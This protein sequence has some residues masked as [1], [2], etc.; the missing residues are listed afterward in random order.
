MQT[1]II[2]T[3]VILTGGAG[4][5]WHTQQQLSSIRLTHEELLGTAA[6]LGITM[7]PAHPGNLLYLTNHGRVGREVGVQLAAAEFI[8]FAKDMA[9]YTEAG[10]NQ[11]AGP[12][13]QRLMEFMD[14]MMALNSAQ[15]K[16]LIAE[17]AANNELKDEIRQDLIGFSIMTLANEQPHAALR[18]FDESSA[19]FT[20][21]RVGA[22]VLATSLA[23]WAKDDPLAALKWLHH[24]AGKKA[25][26][27]TEDT[28]LGMVSAA[29]IQYPKFA[30]KLIADLDL[31]DAPHAIQCVVDAADTPQQR[32]ATIAGLRAYLDTLNDATAKEAT[33]SSVFHDLALGSM[34]DGF[35]SASQWLASARLTPTELENF[36]AGLTPQPKSA[37][38]GRWIEWLGNALPPEQAEE[39]IRGFVSTWTQNDCQAAGQWLGSAADSAAKHTAIRAYAETVASY[40]PQ[41]A[42]QWALTMPEGDERDAT[43]K[44]IYQNWPKTD[45]AAIE[46]AAAFAKEHGIE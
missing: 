17:V 45:A 20:D 19:L 24:H 3:L 41:V 15:F 28:K 5:C 33:A 43:L 35:E 30:F 23:C 6:Q 22:R 26:L 7:D 11:L 14:R 27:I 9:A 29:A 10:G 38:T 8:A 16:A 2:A 32:S 39:R 25:G 13:Q 18:I 44:Q 37:D 36:A 46:A 40:H 31:N 1:P 4:L 42:A 12:M 21:T 34:R